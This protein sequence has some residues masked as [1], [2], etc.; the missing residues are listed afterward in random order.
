RRLRPIAPPPTRFGLAG[1]K[2]SPPAGSAP[3]PAGSAQVELAAADAAEEGLPLASAEQQDGAG[4]V[5]GVADRHLVVEDGDLDTAVEVAQTAGP[6]WGG[7]GQVLHPGSVPAAGRR[8][9]GSPD[10]LTAR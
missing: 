9:H 4:P 5:L 7:G 6:P 1:S 2:S 8:P 10:G 3:G